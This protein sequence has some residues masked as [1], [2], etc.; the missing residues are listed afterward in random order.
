[1]SDQNGSRFCNKLRMLYSGLLWSI[2]IPHVLHH[3]QPKNYRDIE[4]ECQ[5]FCILAKVQFSDISSAFKSY[6][7][8]LE[9]LQS[10]NWRAES[11]PKHNKYK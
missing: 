7:A 9:T 11:I 10:T 5:S 4:I 3:A 8:F 6:T 1:M 2:C